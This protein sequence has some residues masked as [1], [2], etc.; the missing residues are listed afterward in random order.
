MR[1]EYKTLR[2]KERLSEINYNYPRTFL[3]TKTP[4]V[5]KTFLMLD[6]SSACYTVCNRF[7]IYPEKT[8]QEHL[9]NFTDNDFLLNHDTAFK[10][11]CISDDALN[12]PFSMA[13]KQTIYDVFNDIQTY[14]N[15][16]KLT[17]I[18]TYADNIKFLIE[19]NDTIN[20]IK[21]S[22]GKDPIKY[23]GGVGFHYTIGIERCKSICFAN[24]V[25]EKI[26]YYEDID[27]GVILKLE[28]LYREY[29]PQLLKLCSGFQPTEKDFFYFNNMERAINIK[30][31][32]E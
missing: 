1:K 20:L 25:Y 9:S 7:G 14:I 13:Y 3:A 32:N 10:Y 11:D 27:K 19:D 29:Y 31:I 23:F 28:H 26:K 21:E 4:D 5:N 18:S 22:W 16:W 15:Q 6:L 17:H 30:L 2:V 8:W 12:P 24:D